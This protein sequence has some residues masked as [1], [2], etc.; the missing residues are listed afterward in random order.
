MNVVYARKQDESQWGTGR[1]SKWGAK[2]ALLLSGDDGMVQTALITPLIASIAIAYPDANELLIDQAVSITAMAMIPAMLCTSWLA[3]RFD[4]KHLI[5]LGTAI[6]MTAGVSAMFAPNMAVLI[7]LRAVLG[8]GAGV[9][10]PLVPSSIAYLF[11]EQEKNQMLGWMNACGAFLSF[12]LSMAA[13]WVATVSWRAA[14]LFYLIFVPVLVIQAVFLP[15]FKPERQEAEERGVAKEPLN[16]KMWLVGIAM[17][18]YMALNMVATFKLSLFVELN[19]IGTPADSGTA[20]SCMTGASFL[21]S[22]FFSQYLGALKRF[23]PVVSLVFSSLAYL[24]LSTAANVPMV[25]AG[26]ALQGLSMGTLNP[27]FMSSMSRVAP[28]SRKTLGMTMMC[29]FQL[30]GQ[31]ITPYYM[32]AATAL[33]FADERALFACTAGV[34]AAVAVVAAASALMAA[35]REGKEVREDS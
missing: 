17:L 33:G 7:C 15:N 5:L 13:G 14:F 31:I 20:I 16:A 21:I 11:C 9:A 12:T 25:F 1:R 10:F 27:F 19:G 23:A 29:I 3:R 30:G 6:F 8:I 26:M 18:L 2:A 22:L 35:R 24:V 32:L 34:F 4:K 28:D